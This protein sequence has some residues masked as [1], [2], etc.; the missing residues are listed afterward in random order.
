MP[1]L[2]TEFA[3]SQLYR[4]SAVIGLFVLTVLSTQFI[5]RCFSQLHSLPYPPGPKPRPFIGNARD[6]PT[7]KPWLTYA[8]WAKQ[9]GI[10]CSDYILLI[11]HL[12]SY[13]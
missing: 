8:N 3:S 11:I 13:R 12:F 4:V 6:I 5:K 7:T 9:Y 2:A 10:L 1:F